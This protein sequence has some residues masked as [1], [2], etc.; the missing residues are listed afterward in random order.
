MAT[1]QPL[2]QDA[3]GRLRPEPGAYF[4]T[5]NLTGT[6]RI[7][8]ISDPVPPARQLEKA[9]LRILG[10]IVIEGYEIMGFL[11]RCRP[12]DLVVAIEGPL[13]CNS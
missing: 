2:A 7:T 3:L 11:D 9:P 1:R 13:H 6:T 4:L 10:P 8:Q 12:R 5:R